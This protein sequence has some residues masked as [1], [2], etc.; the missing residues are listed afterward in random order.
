[1]DD[2]PPLEK[3]PTI[4]EVTRRLTEAETK[5]LSTLGE[6]ITLDEAEELSKIYAP[7]IPRA[8]VEKQ[9]TI[10]RIKEILSIPKKLQ[11]WRHKK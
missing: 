7:D 9:N 5:Q 8:V 3:L 1:M 4:D 2:E 10:S 11:R 6:E